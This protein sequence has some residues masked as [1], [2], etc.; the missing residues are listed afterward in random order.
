VLRPNIFR[1][2]VAGVRSDHVAEIAVG[3][4][5][6]REMSLAE[7]ALEGCVVAIVRRGEKLLV[8]KGRTRIRPGDVL[9][10]V[11]DEAAIRG[12]RARLAQEA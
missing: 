3:E 11:G 12:A 8:P 10:V 7:L 4:N 2:L 1:L 9:T 5:G 6:S